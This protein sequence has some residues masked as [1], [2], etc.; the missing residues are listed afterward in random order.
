MNKKIETLESF[1]ADESNFIMKLRFLD[2]L[3]KNN[4]QI[5]M[6][7]LD[8]IGAEIKEKDVIEKKLAFLLIEIVPI[9]INISASYSEEEQKD[10]LATIDQISMKLSEILES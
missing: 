7:I 2:G 10:I 9:L 8:D 5:F 1:L 3:D 6:K 4:V